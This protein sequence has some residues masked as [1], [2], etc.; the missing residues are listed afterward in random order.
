MHALL[1]FAAIGFDPQIRG[2]LVVLVAAVILM[3]SVFMIL[4]TNSG[5]RA[6]FLITASALFGWMFLMGTVWVIYGIGFKGRDPAW[7]PT[8]INLTRQAPVSDVPEVASLPSD[9]QLPKAESI[10]DK[11]P[12][13]HAMVLGSEGEK[14]VPATL[15]KLKTATQSMIIMKVPDTDGVAKKSLKTGGAILNS[16]QQVKDLVT[17][18]G[19][20]LNSAVNKQAAQLRDEIEKPLGKWCLLTEDDTRRG[21]AVASTDAALAANKTFGDTTDTSKYIVKDVFLLGGKEPCHPIAEQSQFWR[22]R[23]RVLTTLEVKNP[24][25]LAVTTLVKTKDQVAIAGQAPPVAAAQPGASTVSVIQ[26]RNLGS[27]R[28]VPFLVMLVSLAGFIV[29]TTILHYRDK[30]AMQIRAAFTATGK[31]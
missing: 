15:T 5:V 24:K 14:Y 7:V 19:A 17:R 23:H 11:Y 20:A 21:D 10:L 6:G 29:F 31:K 1:N 18:G 3:G 9:D 30:T 4:A 28:F 2:V 13:I 25:M 26:L 22:V 12:L 27:K 8:D 16:N